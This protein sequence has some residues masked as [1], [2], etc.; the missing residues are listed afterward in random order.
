RAGVLCTGR[1]RYRLWSTYRRGVAVL[2]A[3]TAVSQ[4][5]AP[6]DCD[7]FD[8]FQVLDGSFQVASCL[9]L[10]GMPDQLLDLRR[11]SVQACRTELP[12][13][14]LLTEGARGRMNFHRRSLGGLVCV[15][16]NARDDGPG[17]EQ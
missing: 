4:G 1:R 9:R 10:T 16:A 8:L 5:I 6:H 12:P 17:R 3:C 7:R 2:P 15:K 14:G 11:V 13:G